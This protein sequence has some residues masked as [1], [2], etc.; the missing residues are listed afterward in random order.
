MK[1]NN[2]KSDESVLKNRILKICLTGALLASST[3]FFMV[4]ERNNDKKFFS[5]PEGI[6]QCI[7]CSDG[8]EASGILRNKIHK[9]GDVSID[10]EQLVDMLLKYSDQDQDYYERFLIKQDGKEDVYMI[11]GNYFSETGGEVVSVSKT[12]HDGEVDINY[13][14]TKS[15]EDLMGYELKVYIDDDDVRKVNS[16]LVKK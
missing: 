16:V 15:Y 9:I 4:M 5:T 6:A 3:P 10:G 8:E 2:S 13:L 7:M 1:K 12:F 14:K 11:D